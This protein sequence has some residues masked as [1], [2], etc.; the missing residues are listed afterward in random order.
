[1]LPRWLLLL[2]LPLFTLLGSCSEAP[3]LRIGSNQWPGYEPVYLA[4]DLG[5]LARDQ[6]KLVELPSSTDV[7]QYLRN[8]SL[9][10]GMLTLD[11]VISLLAEGVHLRVV[12]VLDVSNGADA[13]VAQAD[14]HSLQELQG[15]RVGVE[16]SALGALMLESMLDA[17]QLQAG[18]ITLVPLTVDRQ[19]Q[20]FLDHE[21]DAVITFE[22][23][24]S[25]LLA[26]GAVELFNSRQIPGRIIDVLALREEVIDGQADHIRALLAGYFQARRYL[27]EQPRLATAR[28]APRTQMSTDALETA[29]GGLSLPDLEANRRWLADDT[30]RL[31]DSASVL[32][33]LMAER[34]LIGK[35]P[36]LS[37]LADGRFLPEH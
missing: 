20:A 22:P 5:T 8:G 24:R 1:M 27:D 32:V 3:P 29:F 7:M 19:E 34:G 21:V 17:A 11:E 30:P 31:L 10:G 2:L 16:L 14:I 18:Q 35:Q 33:R 15:M 23:T 37:R 28:M 13:V 12:L 36:D 6:V 25:H 26:A 4:R 9:D